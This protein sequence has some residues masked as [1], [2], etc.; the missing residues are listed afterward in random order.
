MI[1]MSKRTFAIAEGSR[2]AIWTWLA[3]FGPSGSGKTCSMLR[4]ATGLREIC[5]G[6]IAVIDTENHRA[7]R[8]APS[9]PGAKEP[10]TFLF[11]HLDLLPPFD[12]LD[13]YA[14]V[15]QCVDEGARVVIVDSMTHEHNGTGGVLEQHERLSLELAEKWKT[16]PEKTSQA[17][18]IPVKARRD[19]AIEL[20]QRLPAHI[21]F[22]FRA[23]EKTKPDAGGKPQ[24]LGFMAIGGDVWIY[25]C[26]LAGLLLPGAAG[27]PTWR[28]R[29]AGSAMMIKTP[30]YLQAVIDRDG[31]LSEETGRIIARWARELPGTTKDRPSDPGEK[32]YPRLW[33]RVQAAQPADVD[34]LATECKAAFEAKTITRGEAANLSKAIAARREALAGVVNPDAE[35]PP[36]QP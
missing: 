10:G 30:G 9:V 6:Q 17:A 25:E 8:Y 15:K 2:K 31:P 33:A 29:D 22:G 26:E 21:L 12:P 28:S 36:V 34:A 32:P 3:F 14:A 24:E 35:P 11:R 18:W 16:R 5:G 7:E 1:E 19:K 13:Y 4:I 27:V 23:K 20:M